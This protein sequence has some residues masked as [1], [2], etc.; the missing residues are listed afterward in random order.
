MIELH[1]VG[2]KPFVSPRGIRFNVARP[3]KYIYIPSAVKLYISL[4]DNSKWHGNKLEFEYPKE[5]MHDE[6]M[7]DII[8]K[9]D[10]NILES[11]QKK[12]DEYADELDRSYDEIKN[13]SHFSEMTKEIYLGNLKFIRSYKI[14]RACNKILYHILVKEITNEIVKKEILTIVVPPSRSFYHLFYSVKDFLVGKKLTSC[15]DI[16]YVTQKGRLK[17]MLNTNICPVG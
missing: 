3:D 13:S 9:K 6:Q 12:L 7:L 2:P 15:V 8:T 11:V 5:M 17:L 1:H 4:K 14:Q 16:S 10:K